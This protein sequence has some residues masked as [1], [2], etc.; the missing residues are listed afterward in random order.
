MSKRKL[1]RHIALPLTC[2]CIYHTFLGMFEDPETMTLIVEP[3]FAVEESNKT[4]KLCPTHK[5][6]TIDRKNPWKMFEGVIALFTLKSVIPGTVAAQ[7]KVNFVFEETFELSVKD[8]P[9]PALKSLEAFDKIVGTNLVQESQLPKFLQVRE[10]DE[11]TVNISFDAQK[12]PRI[13]RIYYRNHDG[14]H[15][16]PPYLKVI[17][18]PYISTYIRDAIYRS[19]ESDL[20][21]TRNITSGTKGAAEPFISIDSSAM[22][23]AFHLAGTKIYMRDLG[24]DRYITDEVVKLCHEIGLS[25][26]QSN[27]AAIWLETA[28]GYVLP[29]AVKL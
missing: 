26:A 7:I 4:W 3:D 5:A 8:I 14:R 19:I 25:D 17:F 21:A 15:L 28:S 23:S 22:I 18:P 13:S 27:G 20:K 16:G 24:G 12:P 6:A 29:R 11:L 1:I 9:N 2:G 10:D